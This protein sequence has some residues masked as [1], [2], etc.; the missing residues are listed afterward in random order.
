M[1]HLFTRTS[2]AHIKI[3]VMVGSIPGNNIAVEGDTPTHCT[4]IV[5]IGRHNVSW[6]IGAFIVGPRSKTVQAPLVD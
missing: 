3:C 6:F 1:A 4:S 5:V 2:K